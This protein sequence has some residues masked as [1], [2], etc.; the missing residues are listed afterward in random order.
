[1]SKVIA[2][3]LIVASAC[4]ILPL[5]GNWISVVLYIVAFALILTKGNN[6]AN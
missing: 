1:M 4:V 3:L 6:P 2:V 5:V